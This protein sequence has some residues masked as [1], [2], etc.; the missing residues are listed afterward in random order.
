MSDA[1]IMALV[2]LM[3]KAPGLALEIRQ[4][5]AKQKVPVDKIEAARQILRKNPEQYF[6]SSSQPTP[7]PPE[8]EGL[9]HQYLEAEPDETKLANGDRVYRVGEKWWV[10]PNGDNSLLPGGAVLVYI[11]QD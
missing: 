10:V 7:E 6:E 5:F 2:Q 1:M 11:I 4:L 3:T 8:T 9:Y